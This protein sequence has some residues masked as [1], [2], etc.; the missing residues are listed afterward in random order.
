MS[1]SPIDWLVV[2]GAGALG[3]TVVAAAFDRFFGARLPRVA[4]A[5]WWAVLA[6]LVLPAG[7]GSPI[8]WSAAAARATPGATDSL[9]A[10]PIAGL[11]IDP[12]LLCWLVGVVLVATWF[13]AQLARTSTRWT[14]LER[15]PASAASRAALERAL[16]AHGVR[17]PVPLFVAADHGPACVGLMRPW[18]VVPEQLDDPTRAHELESVLLHEVAHLRRCD[19]WCRM[20]A[21]A[22]ACAF[23]FHPAAWLAARR[24]AELAEFDCDRRA[25]ERDRRGPAAYRDALLNHVAQRLGIEAADAVID[26]GRGFA[27]RFVHPSSALVA[28]LKALESSARAPRPPVEGATAGLVLL[29]ALACVGPR[30]TI[31]PPLFALPVTFEQLDELEGCLNKR[32]AVMA[33]LAQQRRGATSPPLA[34]NNGSL[35]LTTTPPTQHTR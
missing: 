19:A 1:A 2:C 22:L 24:L 28:R 3:L 20:V 16:A 11:V 30:A 25:A 21:L 13:A 9:T 33:L 12:V 4:S 7:I 14:R 8:G 10:A 31:E 32:F 17:G 34:T 29:G 23:W 35:S 27:A 6:R 18:I 15:R 5:L 26:T